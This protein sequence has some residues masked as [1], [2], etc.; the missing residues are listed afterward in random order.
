MP[1]P[2][3]TGQSSDRRGL[4]RNGGAHGVTR[5][6]IFTSADG[7]TGAGSNHPNRPRPAL[8]VRNRSTLFSPRHFKD[9]RQIHYAVPDPDNFN[10][11]FTRQ[12][13]NEPFFKPIHPPGAPALPPGFGLRRVRGEGTRRFGLGAETSNIQPPTAIEPKAMSAPFPASHRTPRRWRAN[14]TA[15]VL[16]GPMEKIVHFR[17]LLKTRSLSALQSASVFGSA[18]PL[19]N[20]SST[21][22]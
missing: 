21:H 9:F 2:Y 3:P 20:P 10:F 5:P 12:I 13:K 8:P 11:L 17:P 16:F 19:A 22:C 1:L 18:G 15:W 6:T 7:G 4:W 14:S